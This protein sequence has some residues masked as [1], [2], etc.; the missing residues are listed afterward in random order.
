VD[1]FEL[2]G[3]RRELL[4][5]GCRN[6]GLSSGS[7][8]IS[9]CSFMSSSGFGMSMSGALV[10]R[11]REV[12]SH[13]YALRNAEHALYYSNASTNTHANAAQRK[14]CVTCV[15]CSSKQI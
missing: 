3:L 2:T 9:S 14:T 4:G 8:I 1:A 5:G 10:I 11:L 13:E 12:I 6:I 7:G 15:H